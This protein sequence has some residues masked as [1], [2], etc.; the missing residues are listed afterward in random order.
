[1]LRI[2]LGLSIVWGFRVQAL[3]SRVPGIRFGVQGP[4]IK[5]AGT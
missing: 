5:G 1:M 4:G 3:G 2:A